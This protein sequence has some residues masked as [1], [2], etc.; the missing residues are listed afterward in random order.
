MYSTPYVRLAMKVERSGMAI[1]RVWILSIQLFTN[2]SKT[3][4]C[5]IWRL[6]PAMSSTANVPFG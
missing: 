1:D 6:W 4:G 3:A 5:S 2:A